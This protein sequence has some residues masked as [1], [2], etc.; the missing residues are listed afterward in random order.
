MSATNAGHGQHK[1]YDVPTE[2]WLKCLIFG[3]VLILCIPIPVL[4]DLLRVPI[5]GAI[6][7]AVGCIVGFILAMPCLLLD[8]DDNWDR[9]WGE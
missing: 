4:C 7:A 1:L 5:I 3:S 2:K 6:V 9:D 8:G